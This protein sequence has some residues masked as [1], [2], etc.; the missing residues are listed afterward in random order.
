MDEMT[1]WS[2]H[3]GKT[4]DADT[5]F[6][7]KKYVAVGWAK[8][9]DLS[10]LPPDREAFKAHVAAT[11]PD[12][13]LGAIPNNAGQMFR[14]VHEMKTGD[15]VLSS[16]K[17]DHET[18]ISEVRGAPAPFLLPSATSAP[19]CGTRILLLALYPLQIGRT[20]Q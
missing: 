5:L 10:S 12:K 7:K 17:R 6:L 3:A 8:V 2:V 19:P 14:F 16:T 1:L 9:G 20:S 18:H 15:L 13:K 4:G 11:Y